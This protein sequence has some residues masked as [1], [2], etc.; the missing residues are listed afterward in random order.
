MNLITG[1]KENNTVRS[2][3]NKQLRKSI[4]EINFTKRDGT[5]RVMKCTLKSD[6][7]PKQNEE[8]KRKILTNPDLFRV[9]D[10]ESEGWRSFGLDQ[11]NNY[12]IL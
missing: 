1:L 9:W 4:L 10:V 5:E 3:L 7:L 12:K 6:M 8:S 2:I 11:V